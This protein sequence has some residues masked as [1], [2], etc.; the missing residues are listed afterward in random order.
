MIFKEFLQKIITCLTLQT[1]NAVVAGRGDDFEISFMETGF[2]FSFC[3]Q[4]IKWTYK[5]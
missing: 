3:R 1:L 2:V 4:Y 5:G